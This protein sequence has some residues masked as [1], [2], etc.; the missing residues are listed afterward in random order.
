MTPTEIETMARAQYNAIGDTFYKESEILDYIYKAQ[1]DF[2]RYTNML[3]DTFTTVSVVD[4]TEYPFPSNTISIKRLEYNGLKVTPI[5]IKE[6]D[7][8][9]LSSLDTTSSSLSN[10]YWQWGTS[11]FLSFKPETAG[12]EIK[13][14]VYKRP[15]RVTITS[16][17][18]VP[19]EYHTDLVDF[20]NWRMALKDENHPAARDFRD[21]WIAAMREARKLE[22]RKL[23]GDAFA[24]VWIEE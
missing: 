10:F 15:Q 3:R 23:R 24:S 14:F 4:R 1:M 20:V 5:S 13:C 17:I 8:I 19:D 6:N 16:T 2:C 21:Q 7:D 11:F 9:S 22:R 12:V 18:E